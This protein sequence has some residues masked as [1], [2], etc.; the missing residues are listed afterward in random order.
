MPIQTSVSLGE[1]PT[2]ADRVY[3]GL[4]EDA[5]GRIESA[6]RRQD[7]VWAKW[8]KDPRGGILQESKEG[9]RG[10]PDQF[11][12]ETTEN[13]VWAAYGDGFRRNRADDESWREFRGEETLACL[14]AIVAEVV[15]LPD[16]QLQAMRP[17]R[18]YTVQDFRRLVLDV[19]TQIL[20]AVAARDSDRV[21]S[22]TVD[23]LNVME[24]PIATA[25][26]RYGSLRG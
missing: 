2:A 26:R 16:E 8:D 22:A 7:A 13:F 21:R 19:Y 25:V 18:G 14:L 4:S 23:L 5:K 12:V 24:P 6:R 10:L 20:V 1:G 17:R 3:R 11:A 9:I 15:A